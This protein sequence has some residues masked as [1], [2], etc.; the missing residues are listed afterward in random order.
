[1]GV[2]T[3]GSTDETWRLE[4]PHE[5]RGRLQR[6]EREHREHNAWLVSMGI[7]LIIAGFAIPLLMVFAERVVSD[8]SGAPL[9]FAA[10]GLVLL[11]L[12]PVGLMRLFAAYLSR[13][14]PLRR[15]LY[16]HPVLKFLAIAVTFGGPILV[17]SR[18][19]KP[20][21]RPS[22]V[23][24]QSADR[25]DTP[26]DARPAVQEFDDETGVATVLVLVFLVFGVLLLVMSMHSGPMEPAY[27]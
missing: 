19:E 23:H 2:P 14:D 22:G 25:A 7:V 13:G 26:Q 18:L 4:D 24:P 20:A 12:V 15:A 21:Q 16:R 8:D 9:H 5:L 10:W 27:Y 6:Y 1:M 17:G 3:G 11:A